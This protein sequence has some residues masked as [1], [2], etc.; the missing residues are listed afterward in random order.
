VFAAAYEALAPRGRTVE[1]PPVGAA[2]PGWWA[3]IR[4][5]WQLFVMAPIAAAVAGAWLVFGSLL[6]PQHPPLPLYALEAHGGI[7]QM[8]GPADETARRPLELAPGVSLELVMRPEDRVEG[9]VAATLYWVKDGQVRRWPAAIEQAPGG[10][11]RVR[12]PVVAPFGRGAG[13]IV[14]VLGR[15]EALPREEQ[16]LAAEL[17]RETASTRLLRWPV[18]WR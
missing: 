12:G 11:M 3:A 1:L 14:V 5:R 9:P 15:P 18:F 8:R 4:Q 6:G 2:G 16:G 7:A 13:E 10:A 17:L